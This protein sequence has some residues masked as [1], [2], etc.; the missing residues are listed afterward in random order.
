MFSYTKCIY[1][2]NNTVIVIIQLCIYYGIDKVYIIM[3][4]YVVGT[5]ACHCIGRT[6]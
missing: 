3:F 4:L 1:T 2:N 6:V 5:N